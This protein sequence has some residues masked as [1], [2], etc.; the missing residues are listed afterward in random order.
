MAEIFIENRWIPWAGL[1]NVIQCY[2]PIWEFE[3]EF[4]LS[5]CFLA[6]F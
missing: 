2:A 1:K 4:D 5:C 3:F 6:L